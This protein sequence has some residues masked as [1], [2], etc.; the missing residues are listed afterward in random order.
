MKNVVHMERW[1][2]TINEIGDGRTFEV[3]SLWIDSTSISSHGVQGTSNVQDVDIEECNEGKC[4][5]TRSTV[6]TPNLL[7]QNV[8]NRVEI[9]DLLE[10]IKIG[11][12]NGVM[13]EVSERGVSRPRD[14]GDQNDACDHA[15]LDLEGQHD[16]SDES[17]T[18]YTNPHHWRA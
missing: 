8:L 9:N 5:L 12:S 11:V 15:C 3:L 7:L 18:E 13:R 4:E 14:D 16:G 6:Q 10:E 17:S 1:K 2:R